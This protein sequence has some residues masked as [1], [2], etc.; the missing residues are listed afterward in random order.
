MSAKIKICIKSMLSLETLEIYYIYTYVVEQK[1]ER[2]ET[3][4]ERRKKIHRC[5]VNI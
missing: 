1:F 2:R 4:R 5:K 3:R